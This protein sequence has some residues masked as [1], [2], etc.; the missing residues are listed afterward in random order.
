MSEMTR[1]AV[2]AA[3]DLTRKEQFPTPTA[4]AEAIAAEAERLDELIGDLAQT[5]RDQ[6]IAQFREANRGHLPPFM[7]TVQIGNRARAQA[8]ELILH[9]ELGEATEL[10]AMEED[11]ETFEDQSW[12]D[13]PDRWK[14]HTDLLDDP[15]PEIE[16][17]TDEVW[18]EQTIRFRVTAAFLMQTRYEDSQPIPETPDDPLK[19]RFTDLVAAE[20]AHSESVLSEYRRMNPSS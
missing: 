18:P 4:R 6:G 13:S 1:R 12:R 7:E 11:E 16:A 17:L 5:L 20:V 8:E 9:Q 14:D 2:E 15:T 3:W 19:A 10:A